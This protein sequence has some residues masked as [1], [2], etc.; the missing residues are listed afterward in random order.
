ML[1]TV[2]TEYKWKKFLSTERIS[3]GLWLVPKFVESY[4]VLKS[5][6]SCGTLIQISQQ[7]VALSEKDW[8]ISQL[9]TVVSSEPKTNAAQRARI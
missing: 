3:L 8:K 5:T 9:K 2:F 6:E 1:T 7:V 4:E